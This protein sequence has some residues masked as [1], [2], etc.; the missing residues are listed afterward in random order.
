[1]TFDVK[2]GDGNTIDSY[3]TV[4]NN[5]YSVYCIWEPGG[6]IPAGVYQIGL[7]DDDTSDA[8]FIISDY[9]EIK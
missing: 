9:C 5:G 6:E 1:M 7:F 3:V 8:N 2:D 4:Q